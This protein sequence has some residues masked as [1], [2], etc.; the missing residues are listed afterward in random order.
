MLRPLP[1]V[2]KQNREQLETISAS[3]E[4]R[5]SRRFC[6]CDRGLRD[7]PDTTCSSQEQSQQLCDSAVGQCTPARAEVRTFASF[8][9]HWTKSPSPAPVALRYSDRLQSATWPG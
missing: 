2:S 6:H 8:L 9:S 3:I 5:N 1:R 7:R 4:M